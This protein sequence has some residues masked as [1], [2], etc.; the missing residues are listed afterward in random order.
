M[1][2]EYVFIAEAGST[3]G[4]GHVARSSRLYRKFLSAGH[5]AEFLKIDTDFDH[6]S[7]PL[8]GLVNSNLHRKILVVDLK[9]GSPVSDLIAANQALFQRCFRVRMQILDDFSARIPGF[10]VLN[11]NFYNANHEETHEDEGDIVG[12]GEYD[13]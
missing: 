7:A 12:E 4:G 11:Q 2:S 6:W 1:K 10:S 13:F 5:S 9:S 3:V 8:Y